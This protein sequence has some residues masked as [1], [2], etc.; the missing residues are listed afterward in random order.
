MNKE[1]YQTQQEIH[2]KRGKYERERRKKFLR[3]K[4]IGQY[5]VAPKRSE[6]SEVLNTVPPK[7]VEQK[8]IMEYSF[9][10]SI[11]KG[12]KYPLIVAIGLLIAGFEMTYPEVASLSVGSVMIIVYDIVKNKLGVRLP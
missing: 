5:L 12:I 2:I 8:K 7:I 11:K 4:H 3:L 1:K 9:R 10:K 6:V